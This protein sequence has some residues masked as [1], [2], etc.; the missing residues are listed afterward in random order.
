MEERSLPRQCV[1]IILS[2]RTGPRTKGKVELATN[3]AK[4][5]EQKR[6]KLL[7]DDRFIGQITCVS[8]DLEAPDTPR[9]HGDSFISIMLAVAV[10]F[11]YYAV[12]RK[13]GTATICNI[14]DIV[15]YSDKSQPSQIN[16]IGYKKSLNND[17]C[18]ICGSINLKAAPD[19]LRKICEKCYTIW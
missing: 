9:G 7:D 2:N 6:I 3:F 12:D 15:G 1:P 13:M 11:D 8:A 10:Y 4:L 18:K 17:K 14:Q 5:V 16:N 19:G